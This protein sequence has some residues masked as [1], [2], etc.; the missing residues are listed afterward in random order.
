[1]QDGYFYHYYRWGL[2]ILFKE[3]K[4]R[5][6]IFH[7]NPPNDPRFSK[8]K[9]IF[10]KLPLPQKTL[11]SSLYKETQRY[12]KAMND[13]NFEKLFKTSHKQIEDRIAEKKK[14]LEG[15]LKRKGEL[16]EEIPGAEAMVKQRS[17]DW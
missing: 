6:I 1:M 10:Y 13:V 9:R 8:Y 17:D 3:H 2:D 16:K 14:L 12:V 7:T 11:D 4:V 5:K 15:Y